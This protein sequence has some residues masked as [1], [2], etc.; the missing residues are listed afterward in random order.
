MSPP[1]SR[2]RDGTVSW[3]IA[4]LRKAPQQAA[5]F[6]GVC[7]LPASGKSPLP[8]LR[9]V[10]PLRLRAPVISSGSQ[11]WPVAQVCTVTAFYPP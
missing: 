8:L 6:R 7:T 9:E 1:P 5:L 11:L 2:R 3:R 4:G 10:T